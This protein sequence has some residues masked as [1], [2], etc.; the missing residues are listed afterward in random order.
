MASSFIEFGNYGFWAKDGFVEAV[1]LCLINEIEEGDYGHLDWIS[2]YKIELA[3]Q[4]LPIIYGG[5]SMEL[6]EFITDKDRKHILI[7]LS[8]KII[9]KT[10]SDKKYLTGN[11][12]HEMRYRS[13]EILRDSKRTEFEDENDFHYWVNYSRWNECQLDDVQDRYAHAF[14]LLIKLLKGELVATA[15]SEINYWNF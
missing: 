1:Q 4:S 13:M 15:S 6:S 9:A 10:L 14:K 11:N 12:L 7:E 5:M 3:F 2:E 8:E